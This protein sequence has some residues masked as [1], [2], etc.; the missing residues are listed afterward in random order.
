M[1]VSLLLGVQFNQLRHDCLLRVEAVFGFVEAVD[2]YSN[3][4]AA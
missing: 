2:F 1:P 4:S 3:N